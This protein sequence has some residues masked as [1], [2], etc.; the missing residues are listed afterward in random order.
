[1]EVLGAVDDMEIY[2]NNG[3]APRR[4]AT[5]MGNHLDVEDPEALAALQA[6]ASE[7]I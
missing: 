3:E 4:I 5:K 6:K 2:D 1:M 7:A